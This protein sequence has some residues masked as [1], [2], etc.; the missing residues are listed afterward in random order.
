MLHSVEADS[1]LTHR[2]AL[3]PILVCHQLRSGGNL[4][5]ICRLMANFG[6]TE[7][8]LS[9]PRIKDFEEARL[10]AVE[11][12]FILESMVQVP[13]LKSALQ[14][15]TYVMGTTSRQGAKHFAPLTPEAGIE[16]LKQHAAA[17]KVALVLGGE[18]RG[19]SDD[20]LRHCHD[21]IVINTPG[22]QPSMNVAQAAAVLLYLCSRENVAAAEVEH[23][24]PSM[25]LFEKLES[26]MKEALTLSEFLN[27]QNPEVALFELKRS[28]VRAHLSKR[29]LEVWISAFDHLLRH[30]KNNA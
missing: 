2:V 29:D 18:K 15:V 4:G 11:S 23:Q 3:K 21:V 13:D 27:P 17:G 28:L 7:L 10:M 30:V 25:K 19:L 9:E 22:P 1:S 26:K 8:I 20:D 6:F 5:S 12:E 16:Q 14:D 24:A